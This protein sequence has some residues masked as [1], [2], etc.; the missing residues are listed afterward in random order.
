MEG[1]APAHLSPSACGHGPLPTGRAG[2]AAKL[3][4]IAQIIREQPFG[5]VCQEMPRQ[6]M[7]SGAGLIFSDAQV[8]GLEPNMLAPLRAPDV[9]SALLR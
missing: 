3:E 8:A 7:A 9:R 1:D 5:D 6:A 2:Q 4:E